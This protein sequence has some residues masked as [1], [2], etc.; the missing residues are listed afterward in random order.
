MIT[1]DPE[2]G[3]AEPSILRTVAATRESCAGI[4]GVPENLG[5][6]RAGD[7]IYLIRP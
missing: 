3:D 7:L 1:L 6:M 5:T 4:Y 2:T